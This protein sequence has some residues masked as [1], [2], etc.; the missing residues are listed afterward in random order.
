M[1]YFTKLWYEKIQEMVPG[2]FKSYAEIVQHED[3]LNAQDECMSTTMDM[4]KKELERQD[5][6]PNFRLDK[7]SLHDALLTKLCKE[8][9]NIILYIQPAPLSSDIQQLEFLDA[10]VL[11]EDNMLQPALASGKHRIEFLYDEV[12]SVKNG[13][14]SHFLFSTRQKAKITLLELTIGYRSVLIK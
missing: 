8:G 6:P 11:Y 14:E 5:F 12:Y 2:H 10:Y 1:K 4:Y 7:I 9:K 3:A 13:Y